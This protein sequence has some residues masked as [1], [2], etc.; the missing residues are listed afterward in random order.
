[1]KGTALLQLHIHIWGN[2]R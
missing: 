2:K 1:M